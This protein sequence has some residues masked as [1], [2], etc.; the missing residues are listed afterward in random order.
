MAHDEAHKAATIRV[1]RLAKKRSSEELQDSGSSAALLTE[2]LN[3][4]TLHTSEL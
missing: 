3:L 2:N 4:V 1:V